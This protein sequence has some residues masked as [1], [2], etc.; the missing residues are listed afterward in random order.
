MTNVGLLLDFLQL[1]ILP[2]FERMRRL[3][4]VKKERAKTNKNWTKTQK[5]PF[6]ALA[7][8]SELFFLLEQELFVAKR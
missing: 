6:L 4:K 8:K 5:T 2:I 7:Q 3:L 1:Q